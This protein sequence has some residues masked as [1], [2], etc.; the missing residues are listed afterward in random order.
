MGRGVT[1]RSVAKKNGLVEH[2]ICINVFNCEIALVVGPGAGLV[3]YVKW[4]L[5][6]PDYTLHE[7]FATAAGAFIHNDVGRAILWM[8][9]KPTSA[10]ALSFLAHEAMHATKWLLERRDVE[11]GDET[12]E[13]YCY[14]LGHIF[15]D[16]LLAMDGQ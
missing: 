9:K 1:S 13:V 16:A 10:H 2:D 14:T 8:E 11:F 15:R 7:H 5:D 6:L 4:K 3:E 12:E